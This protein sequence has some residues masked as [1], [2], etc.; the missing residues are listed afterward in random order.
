MEHEF[1]IQ[2]SLQR[3]WSA[4]R[5]EEGLARCVPGLVLAAGGDSATGKTGRGRLRVQL[6]STSIT[7]RG[8]AQVSEPEG[9]PWALDF[10][11]EG[12]EARGDGKASA[13]IRVR[14]AEEG[15]GTRL[16][17]AVDVNATGR[18]NEA[19]PETAQRALHRLLDRFGANLSQALAASAESKATAPGTA[20]EVVD[21]LPEP[22]VTEP[23][24]SEPVAAE[25]VEAELVVAELV[26]DEPI[27]DQR[28]GSTDI[29]SSGRRLLPEVRIPAPLPTMRSASVWSR[30]RRV[31][32]AALTVLASAAASL[33]VVS[34]RRR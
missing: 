14:L 13:L 29:A 28:Y 22:V 30:I 19:K 9:V 27:V 6:G 15:A 1:V 33:I 23:V 26:A 4:L 11:L 10:S 8:S 2:A 7:Y 24:A 20:D 12:R 18:W 16:Q 34:R 31:L 3:V 5:H 21:M 32:P 25:P 17:A